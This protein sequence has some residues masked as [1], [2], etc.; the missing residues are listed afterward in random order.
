[1]RKDSGDFTYQSGG[2]WKS[3]W[4]KMVQK[5]LIK[6]EDDN[7]RKHW[8]Y[9]IAWASVLSVGYF[10]Q[11][12]SLLEAMILWVVCFNT[13]LITSCVY[14]LDLDSSW[15]HLGACV[16]ASGSAVLFIYLFFYVIGLRVALSGFLFFLFR[17]LGTV[18]L[19]CQSLV[20]IDLSHHLHYFL[21]HT[22]NAAHRIHGFMYAA[23]WYTLHLFGSLAGIISTS[24]VLLFLH[25]KGIKSFLSDFMETACFFLMFVCVIV[26]LLTVVNKGGLVPTMVSLY[27]AFFCWSMRITQAGNAADRDGFVLTVQTIT[28]VMSVI[29]GI[30]H[31]KSTSLW[32]TKGV[33]VIIS[34]VC[35]S[36]MPSLLDG[37]ERSVSGQEIYLMESGT[38]S[39]MGRADGERGNKDGTSLSRSNDHDN[40]YETERS[41]LIYNDAPYSLDNNSNSSPSSRANTSPTRTLFIHVLLALAACSTTVLS[42]SWFL[43]G[44]AGALN[45]SWRG[46]WAT[47]QASALF[48]LWGVYMWSMR[49][50]YMKMNYQKIQ[51]QTQT[52][53]AAAV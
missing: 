43:H 46:Y 32:G 41:G 27:S 49:H 3:F 23:R 21:L 36:S 53:V 37:L 22:A 13:T 16:L 10:T 34:S 15:A 5:T 4:Q 12:R 39:L 9:F 19:C 42:D 40:D 11:S 35:C 51:I 50:T 2:D 31:G 20:I 26:S 14:K 33:L 1:M 6:D 38:S 30:V 29:Y 47:L 18:W 24:A 44:G 45:K 48:V 7:D 28:L 52:A 17:T 8:L 25:D